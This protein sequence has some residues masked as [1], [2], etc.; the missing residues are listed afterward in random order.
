MPIV[1]VS[2]VVSEKGKLRA[3]AARMLAD[4]IAR[5]FN[6]E[7]G[8][9]W[10]RVTELHESGYAENGTSLAKDELPVFVQVLHADWPDQESRST[11]ARAIAEA[12]AFSLSRQVELVHVIY[13]PSGRG[14]VALGGKLV[15]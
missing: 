14:R 8:R 13:A 11:E 12:V 1:D 7:R 3:D 5:V 9:V 4:S 6:A 10:V 15:E 2:P